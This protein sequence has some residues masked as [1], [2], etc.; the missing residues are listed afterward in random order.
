M[1]PIIAEQALISTAGP[2]DILWNFSHF[3]DERR[4][5]LAQNP[6]FYEGPTFPGPTTCGP[7]SNT[8]PAENYEGTIYVLTNNE[9]RVFLE[10]E[11][12]WRAFDNV[13]RTNN[14]LLFKDFI[15]K[16]E[17]EEIVGKSIPP[18]PHSWSFMEH[19][20]FQLEHEDWRT[21]IHT[22]LDST[23]TCIHIRANVD[24]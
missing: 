15:G 9:R 24:H 6:H 5:T 2:T 7:A 20:G 16:F 17:G 11:Q 18:P 23:R 4:L 1:K 8:W 3:E 12:N 13:W 22:L 21:P 14:S 10:L 19:P